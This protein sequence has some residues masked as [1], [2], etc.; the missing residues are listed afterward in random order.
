MADND[1]VTKFGVYEAGPYTVSKSAMNMVVSKFQAEYET[2]GVLFLSIS[3]GLVDT[4]IGEE[5]K[6]IP[7]AMCFES[8]LT[9]SQCKVRIST[10]RCP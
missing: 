4:G 9:N 7:E 1:L 10:K 6:L 5:C 2:N 8:T 3:P